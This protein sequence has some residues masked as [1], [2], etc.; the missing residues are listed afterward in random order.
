[1]GQSGQTGQQLTPQ[2]QA[3]ADLD[4]IQGQLRVWW[5]SAKQWHD[6]N[7]QKDQVWYRDIV[8]LFSDANHAIL[9]AELRGGSLDTSFIDTAVRPIINRITG[10]LIREGVI[11]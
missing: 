4:R 11:K 2:E 7:P 3:R 10:I 1:M 8:P 6:L 9:E 5:D